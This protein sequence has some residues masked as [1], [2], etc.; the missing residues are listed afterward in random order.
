MNELLSNKESLPITRLPKAVLIDMLGRMEYKTL[1]SQLAMS[2]GSKIHL[3][4]VMKVVETIERAERTKQAY[5]GTLAP[6]VEAMLGRLT[7]EYLNLMEAIP[8]HLAFKLLEE[9]ERQT[10]DPLR[11]HV[12]SIIRAWLT[13]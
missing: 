12:L 2:A 8:N 7:Q 13:E 4:S 9:V 10:R 1:L 11:R 3:Y 5:N 6:E